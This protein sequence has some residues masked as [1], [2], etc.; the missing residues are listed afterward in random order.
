[1][2]GAGYR[3]VDS[4]AAVRVRVR[5]RSDFTQQE[6]Q[7]LLRWLAT[8]YDD[9]PWRTAHWAELGTGPHVL[10][11]D[12]TGALLAHAC[13]AWVPMRIGDL[14][15][16]AG[17]LEDVATRADARGLGYGSAVV[18]AAHA[19]IKADADLGFLATG[20]Q[21]FYERLGWVRWRGPSSV[22]ERDGSCTRTPDE[23]ASL[24]ALLFERTP[25]VSVD[26]PVMRPRRDP[27]EAW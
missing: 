12:D 1:M 16:C 27:D 7:G 13:I 14:D 10:A 2:T 3:R 23:D 20:S 5:E 6:L 9:G 26:A 25:A 8:A 22:R 24:M 19:L 18:R 15:L 17:Y 4:L 21:P 11:E